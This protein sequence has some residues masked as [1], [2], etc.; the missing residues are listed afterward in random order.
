MPG[1]LPPDSVGRRGM[2]HCG[3]F[4]SLKETYVL[5]KSYMK[6]KALI[7]ALHNENRKLKEQIK[8]LEDDINNR[9]IFND[10]D[11]FYYSLGDTDSKHPYCPA[12][13][14][15]SEKRS[16]IPKHTLKCPV[17]GNDYYQEAQHD[18]S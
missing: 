18:I 13:Y 7:A 15:I 2:K 10:N 4:D 16:R 3:L 6:L 8:A 17:C 12:C 5:L 11:G 9:L 14:D 1:R